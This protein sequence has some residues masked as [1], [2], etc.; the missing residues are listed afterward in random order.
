MSLLPWS[1]IPGSGWYSLF[2]PHQV[3]GGILVPKPGMEPMPSA[4][5]TQSLKHWTARE[6]L[7]DGTI[8]FGEESQEEVWKVCEFH[9]H[10]SKLSA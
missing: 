6:V 5:G 8:E 1:T 7:V 3:A 4:L 10:L 9:V 2:W